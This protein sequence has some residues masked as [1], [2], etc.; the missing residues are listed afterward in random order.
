MG[1]LRDESPSS[2]PRKVEKGL[3]YVVICIKRA[4]CREISAA[5]IALR[6]QVFSG[7]PGEFRLAV[8]YGDDVGNHSA[9][10][11]VSICERMYSRQLVMKT[12]ERL[13]NRERLVL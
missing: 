4:E 12:K 7:S 8:L 2:R 6:D 11:A 1:A 3:H 13:V 5:C 10:T 9:V